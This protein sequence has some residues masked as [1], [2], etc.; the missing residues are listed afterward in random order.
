MISMTSDILD[1]AQLKSGTFKLRPKQ[2]DL[3]ILIK[4]LKKIISSQMEAK[5]LD[6]KV[7]IEED[8]P[9]KVE[10]DNQRIM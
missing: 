9:S 7:K 3:R 5:N 1:F 6:L 8:V 10:A 4:Q 2:F